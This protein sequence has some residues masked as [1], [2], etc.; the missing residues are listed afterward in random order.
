VAGSYGDIPVC[1]IGKD[2]FIANKKAL[3]R[4]NDL[5]DLET[6]GQ[7]WSHQKPITNK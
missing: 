7:E 1:L 5:A 6:L 4:K 2:G 3:G